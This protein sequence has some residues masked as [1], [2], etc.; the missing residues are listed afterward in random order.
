MRRCS[1]TALSL[2]MNSI[3]SS[4]MCKLKAAVM[5]QD[6]FLLLMLQIVA[7]TLLQEMLSLL[8]LIPRLISL[9][10]ALAL[11]STPGTQTQRTSTDLRTTAS[12]L[13]RL[14]LANQT[15]LVSP[16]SVSNMIPPDSS[17]LPPLQLP[18]T[19]PL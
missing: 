8:P 13:T 18:T 2:S 16:L 15:Q 4:I 3:N 14:V 10:L 19:R 6:M 12:M 7:T 11:T 17:L 9:L 5:R 1:P